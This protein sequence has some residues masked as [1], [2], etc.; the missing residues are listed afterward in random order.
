MKFNIGDKVRIIADF[1]GEDTIG[2]GVPIGTVGEIC[3]IWDEI[4]WY[5]F[6]IQIL[7]LPEGFRED[8]LELV[9]AA[10]DAGC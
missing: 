10:V 5:E 1:P 6:P 8:E 2:H 9:E 4:D 7:G 3:F